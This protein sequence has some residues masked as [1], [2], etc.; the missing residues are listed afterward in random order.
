M[1]RALIFDV[2][3]TLAD[4]ERA[5][6]A[7][8]NAAFVSCGVD[9]HWDVPLYNAL[10]QVTGGKERLRHYIALYHKMPG[11][12]DAQITS[13]VETLHAAKT[14]CYVQEV[15]SGALPLRP[16]VGALIDEAQALGLTLAIASTT[17]PANIDALLKPALG[18]QWRSRFA[19][20][21]DGASAPLK[22]P[23]PQAYEQVLSALA[24]SPADCLA[25]EDSQQGLRAATAA[26]LPTVVTPSDLTKHQDFSAAWAVFPS[27]SQVSLT[28]LHA[29]HTRYLAGRSAPSPH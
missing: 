21:A 23:H 29:L 5:H 6:L 4:T 19:A 24:L 15:S 20:I 16:G 26:G 9:W 7:A 10:L 1:L 27:L 18:A 11:K 3:G 28:Q 8:F 22:K 14:A 2:D 25:I 13:W 12:S 17:T